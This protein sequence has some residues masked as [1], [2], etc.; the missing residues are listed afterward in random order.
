MIVLFCA[1]KKKK[2]KNLSAQRDCLFYYIVICFV[3]YL[4]MLIY[5]FDALTSTVFVQHLQNRRK[6]NRREVNHLM[7]EKQ[8]RI[9]FVIK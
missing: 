4:W 1:V 3:R 5:W 7:Q 6:K 8:F 9:D 2:K